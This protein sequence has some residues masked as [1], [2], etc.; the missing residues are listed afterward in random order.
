MEYR[1]ENKKVRIYSHHLEQIGEGRE[2]KIYK[3]NGSLLKL[4][5]DY[6][7]K[8]VLSF[9]DCEYMTK[10]NT[11]RVLLP[12][13]SVT[14]KH[15]LMRGYT[16]SPY[17]DGEADIYEII[18][19]KFLQERQLVQLELIYLGEN[20]VS[21]DDLCLSNFKVFDKFY[22]LDPGSYEVKWDMLDN[23]I[24]RDIMYH[25]A[26]LNVEYFDEFLYEKI[27]L[28][29]IRHY[30]SNIKIYRDFLQNFMNA[31]MGL[32]Y[33]S[34]ME[35]ICSDIVVDIPLKESIKVFLKK[36]TI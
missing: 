16:I 14:D 13:S 25:L 1:I 24:E 15:H 30:I 27:F 34:K 29:Y 32:G 19:K 11:E 31:Y 23:Y 26:N 36:Y 12:T 35:F 4:Y 18:G 3:Y 17:I 22:L 10:L 7:K 6:P 33:G 2:G 21:V 8:D 28:Q 9:K 5:H 20:F